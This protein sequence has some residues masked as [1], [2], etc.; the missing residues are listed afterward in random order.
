MSERRAD[1]VTGFSS[2]RMRQG[3]GYAV[4]GLT[5]LSLICL[6]MIPLGLVGGPAAPPAF[7]LIGLFHWSV[8]RPE[9]VP[10]WLAFVFGLLQDLLWGTPIGVWSSAFLVTVLLARTTQTPFHVEGVGI[11]WIGFVYA[12]GVVSVLV[13]MTT[14]L[15]HLEFL[16]YGPIFGQAFLTAVFYPLFAKALA[17]LHGDAR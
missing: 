7:A 13:W 11:H 5:I 16:S 14:S 8:N 1:N 15:F 12:L 10:Y 3:I 2:P 4:P 17:A 6:S 9:A